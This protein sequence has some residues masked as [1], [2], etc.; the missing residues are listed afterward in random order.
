MPVPQIEAEQ[1]TA[2]TA[3]EQVAGSC[4]YGMI[5]PKQYVQLWQEL[6]QVGVA[7]AVLRV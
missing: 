1:R 3:L 2:L 4:N 6:G 5:L 7:G